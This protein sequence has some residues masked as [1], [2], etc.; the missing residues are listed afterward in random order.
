LARPDF[1]RQ[2]DTSFPNALYIDPSFSV[3]DTPSLSTPF[4]SRKL[5]AS[6]AHAVAG[7]RVNSLREHNMHVLEAPTERGRPQGF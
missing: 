5:E 4:L 2:A 6:A 3:R 7:I 1:H